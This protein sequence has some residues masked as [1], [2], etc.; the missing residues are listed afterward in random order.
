M[1]HP[2]ITQLFC[3]FED[4]ANVYLILEYAERGSLFSYLK[5]KG[6][7]SEQ[8]AFVFFFQTCLGINFLHAHKILHRDLKVRNG[9]QKCYYL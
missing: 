3:F 9:S 4:K 6:R 8:E 1:N 2:H 5:R 7:L